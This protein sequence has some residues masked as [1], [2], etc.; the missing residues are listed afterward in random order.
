MIEIRTSPVL[1]VVQ[2]TKYWAIEH[3]LIIYVLYEMSVRMY[4][5]DNSENYVNVSHDCTTKR[6]GSSFKLL[7]LQQSSVISMLLNYKLCPPQLV[8]RVPLSLS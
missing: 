2:S 6:D 1:S 5:F 7:V 4:T 8:S 3:S